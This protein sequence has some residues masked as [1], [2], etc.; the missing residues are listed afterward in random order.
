MF[1]MDLFIWFGYK[2]SNVQY[3]KDVLKVQPI[4]WI[5]TLHVCSAKALESSLLYTGNK[6]E[7][8]ALNKS[9][10]FAEDTK[11]KHTNITTIYKDK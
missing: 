1:K 8:V 9:S 2:V 5:Q 10:F 11:V 4:D 6:L 7:Q 3:Y